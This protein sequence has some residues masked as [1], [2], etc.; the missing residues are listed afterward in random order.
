MARRSDRLRVGVA[1]VGRMGS[2]HVAALLR[3]DDVLLSAVA[4]PSLPAQARAIQMA[5]AA[6]AG[7]AGRLDALAVYGSTDAMLAANDLDCIVIATP[8]RLHARHCLMA[9]H[10]GIRVLVEKPMA[11]TIDDG[12]ELA[13]EAQLGSDL[14]MVGHIERFNPAIQALRERMRTLPT[15]RPILIQTWRHGDA[16]ADPPEEGVALDL[17]IHDLDLICHLLDDDPVVVQGRRCGTTPIE[18][19]L[20]VELTFNSGTTARTSIGWDSGLR[21]RRIVVHCEHV[22]LEVD[23][24]RQELRYCLPGGQG[25]TAQSWPDQPLWREHDAFFD[26]ARNGGPSPIGARDG[27][28]ALSLAHAAIASARRGHPVKWD[29]PPLPE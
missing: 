14:L 25:W 9:L 17:G 24:Q 16:P 13:H 7:A 23:C 6:M 11:T 20:D 5:G 1:G 3:R 18:Q 29:L 8:A 12:R 2:H 21:Q 19:R 4:D 15:G 26:A 28:R 10:A 27:L 22:D